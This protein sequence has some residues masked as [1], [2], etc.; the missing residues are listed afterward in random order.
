MK[1]ESAYTYVGLSSA[2]G[3]GRLLKSGRSRDALS[4]FRCNQSLLDVQYLVTV[5][6]STKS[7]K[8]GGS[9]GK[10]KVLP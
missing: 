7:T 5:T 4:R 3:T 6:E 8:I 2:M 1:G 9:N 10:E